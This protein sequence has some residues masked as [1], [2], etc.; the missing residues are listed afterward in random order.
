[1]DILQRTELCLEDKQRGAA[2]V[3]TI[4]ATPA[5]RSWRS[6]FRV[7]AKKCTGRRVVFAGGTPYLSGMPARPKIDPTSKLIAEWP[8]S[9]AA[10][11][12]SS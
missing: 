11:L 9:P 1:M 2:F 5:L 12:G 3:P 7:C 4:G 10:T 6:E 8:L